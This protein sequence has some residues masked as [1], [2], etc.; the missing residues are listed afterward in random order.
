MGPEQA[1]RLRQMPLMAW[2]RRYGLSS[3]VACVRG[4]VAL[5][6]VPAE[7]GRGRLSWGTTRYPADEMAVTRQVVLTVADRFLLAAHQ[8]TIMSV[9]G[10][11]LAP[12]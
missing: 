8:G 6:H 10:R 5:G 3:V 7:D 12:S 1:G 9:G 11:N 4:F 2:T